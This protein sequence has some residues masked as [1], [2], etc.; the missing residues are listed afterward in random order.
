MDTM[1][2]QTETSLADVKTS[3]KKLTGYDKELRLAQASLR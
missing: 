1:K 3:L 2:A